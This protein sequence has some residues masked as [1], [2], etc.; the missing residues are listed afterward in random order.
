MSLRS[1][2]LVAIA[3]VLC[4]NA[5][6]GA[7]L[8]GVR[9]R[10]ALRSELQTAML[11]ADRSVREALQA[12]PPAAWTAADLARVVANFDGDRHVQTALVIPG[13]RSTPRSRPFAPNHPAPAWYAAL[14]DPKLEP[15]HEAAPGVSG[16]A[17]VIGPAPQADLADSWLNFSDLMTVLF[18]ACLFGCGL[19]FLLIGQ[20]LR[21]LSQLA[22][23]F[24]LIG[25]GHYQIRVDEGG[26]SEIASIGRAF[27]QMAGQ[28]AGMRDRNRL[29]EEQLL[30][31]QDEE[32]AD[33]A[34]DLHDDIGPYL[35]AVNVDAQVIG[36]LAADGRA[37]EI[38]PQ[39]KAIQT[40]VAHMQARVRDILTRLRPTLA[41]ELGLGPALR[42]LVDF[43]RARCPEIAFTMD[44]RIEEDRLSLDVRE[45]A[46]RVVQESLSNAVRHGQPSRIEV[47]LEPVG[48]AQF[49]VRVS[50]DGRGRKG[51]PRREPGFGILGMQERVAQAGGSLA[52]EQGSARGWTVTA[53]L[54]TARRRRTR[55]R[56]A[57]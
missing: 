30:K 16:T 41:V 53:E 33:L 34:R 3:L 22:A 27:N 5:A 50:D 8:A 43:W 40:G 48:E 13:A 19:V 49:G 15:L 42:D 45:A 44:V 32:R 1:R 36:Q 11:G 6:I 35:F 4:I 24:G 21:P 12:R 46:Y 9:A 17:I 47:V 57:A 23:S 14:I 55:R 31:L 39:V 20:A 38:A 18:L 28:L 54:P 25:S 51:E 52:I 37:Q 56:A 7:A 10:A 2:V 29:L 26:A